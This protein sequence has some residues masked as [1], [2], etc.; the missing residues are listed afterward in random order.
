M[1]ILKLFLYC[2]VD[3][4]LG[5]FQFFTISLCTHMVS[6]CTHIKH[7]FFKVLIATYTFTN[8]WT[9]LLLQIHSNFWCHQTTYLLISCVWNSTHFYLDSHFL[10]YW[11]S[12][13]FMGFPF[14]EMFVHIH[15]YLI[16]LY[17]FVDLYS[18][19]NLRWQYVL[20][21]SSLVAYLLSLSFFNQ[22]LSGSLTL[23]SSTLLLALQC[24][25]H[26]EE[27]ELHLPNARTLHIYNL[28]RWA[29]LVPI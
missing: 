8:K 25:P 1:I 19:L 17:W 15:Y 4:Y 18:I 14:C 20:Q 7:I 5:C 26:I 24:P 29:A 6:L 3:R 21:I 27:R 10:Y 2:Y 13:F 11:D 12:A 16:F 9:F 22:S 23:V 28:V